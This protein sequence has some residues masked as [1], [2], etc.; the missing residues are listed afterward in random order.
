MLA[1][2]AVA[3]QALAQA[4]PG[5]EEAPPLQEEF[6]GRVAEKLGVP[7]EELEEAIRSTELEMLDEAV[8]QGRIRPERA[9]RLRRHIEEGRLLPPLPRPRPWQERLHPGQRL[10]LHAAAEVLDMTPR[11]L[12]GELRQSGQS[13]AQLA[14]EKGVSR[15]ELKSGILEDVERRLNEG[16]ERLREN[17]DDIIDRTPGPPPAP[18]TD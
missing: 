18:P 8:E 5:D 11:E 2:G 14:E 1:L 3:G 9:E 15:E 13:L 12:I 17:I 4:G 10:M 6:L 7:V 16:L